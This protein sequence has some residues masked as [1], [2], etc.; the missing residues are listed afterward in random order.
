MG[1]S[2]LSVS[3]RTPFTDLLE[4]IFH[5]RDVLSRVWG[6]LFFTLRF[7]PSAQCWWWRATLHVDCRLRSC[8]QRRTNHDPPP[9]WPSTS[10]HHSGTSGS[11]QAVRSP[12][13]WSNPWSN[14]SPSRRDRYQRRHRI[15]CLQ[16]CAIS[17]ERAAAKCSCSASCLTAV[18]MSNPLKSVDVCKAALGLSCKSE[19]VC[20]SA[21]LVSDWSTC[22]VSAN[23]FNLSVKIFTEASWSEATCSTVWLQDSVLGCTIFGTSNNCSAIC[24]TRASGICST[25]RCKVRSRL[26]V[27]GNR[28]PRSV[29]GS[30]QNS[31]QEQ[32]SC[33]ALCY[34]VKWIV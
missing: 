7:L 3:A 27:L 11:S 24:G 17:A 16:R 10:L 13:T 25:A 21:P 8:K 9:R 34:H 6:Q 26:E 15:S 28:R 12:V 18:I 4:L 31:A 32:R 23:A 20:P 1:M 5:F 14:P 29:R 30:F 33:A 22:V 19:Y 2:F